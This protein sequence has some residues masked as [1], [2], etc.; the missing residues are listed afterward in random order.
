MTP[1][2]QRAASG[3]PDRTDPPGDRG[4]VSVSSATSSV[5]SG[6]LV[7]RELELDSIVTVLSRPPAIVVIEGEAGIGKT[8]LVQEVRRHPELAGRRFVMG[9]CR[10]IQEPFPL[11]P[12]L[13]LAR[14]L[15]GEVASARL[16]PV[17]GALRPLLPELAELLPPMPEPLED[18]VAARH[19]VF[20]GLLELLR[21]VS[22]VTMV[23]E[24]LH[25]ADEQTVGFL[26]YVMSDPP[27]SLS[28]VV[29]LRGE[30]VDIRVRRLLSQL[31]GGSGRVHV[32]LQPLDVSQTGQLAAAIMESDRVSDEFAAYLCARTGGL[33][34]AVE[35]VMAL[36]RER[37]MV[38]RG[39]EQWQRGALEEL[40]VPTAVRDHVLARASLL[41]K[42]AHSAMEA[43]SV[44]ERPATERLV[45]AVSADDT[46]R[47]ATGLSQAI[48][49]GL[50]VDDGEAVAFRHALASQAIYDQIPG[51]RR[52]A[53]HGRAAA[54][55]RHSATTDGRV[56]E[57]LGQVA[58][59]LRRA[60]RLSEW[61]EVAELAADRAI[62]LEH[63]DEAAR[64]LEDVL[65][66]A[67]IPS[68]DVGRL[69]VKLGRSA[70]ETFGVTSVADLL[71]E[72]L[73]GELPPSVRGELQLLLGVVLDQTGLDHDRVRELFQEVTE[74]PAARGDVRVW[75]ML[76]LA[77]RSESDVSYPE[78][79]RLVEK[80]LEVLP[81]AGDRDFQ[82]FT[83]G[84]AAGLY[85]EMGDPR[86]PEVMRRVEKITGD[87]PRRHPDVK[88]HF[89]LGEVCCLVG[90]HGEADRRLAA[91]LSGAVVREDQRLE[92]V[93]RA[94][95]VVLD[96]C[97]GRWDGLAEEASRLEERL[98]DLPRACQ[99]LDLVTG[100]LAL[101]RGDVAS[102]GQQLARV[103]AQ[104]AGYDDGSGVLQV[105]VGGL[106][107]LA[108]A[109]RDTEGALAT[110]DCYLAVQHEQML[111]PAVYRAL[112]YLVQALV[113][114]GRLDQAASL[115][116][117]CMRALDDRDAP[118]GSG[119][120]PHARG[121]L[122]AAVD[123]A[124]AAALFLTAAE[125]YE[126][127]WCP[128]EAALARESAAVTLAGAG[129]TPE[130]AAPLRAAMAT[131][132]RLAAGWDLDRAAGTARRY[133]MS[134]PA[135]HRGGQKGYGAVLSPREREVAE[136]VAT[137][138]TNQEIAA[139]LFLSTETVKKHLQSIR[140]KLGV[141]S[142]VALARHVSPS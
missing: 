102:A 39:G 78:R 20:R 91:A 74:N 84:K 88:A 113:A 12:V 26:H 51:P 70:I 126:S 118:L 48:E 125:Q 108:L 76:A 42:P 136:L 79:Q 103:R 94:A 141:S 97:C 95:R 132:Q 122:A 60:G 7:A 30:G 134:A 100:L 93:I 8:R 32:V 71:T 10:T 117:Q 73:E 123:P 35:E 59:H 21:E 82:V 110:V 72:V 135:R 128:Y 75:A 65:R 121:H 3:D 130:V 86:W 44:L 11:G 138:L 9:G 52:R 69:A 28:L 37:G 50:L 83:L 66:Y 56:P 54:A 53:L 124:G 96:Y 137:G 41:P 6:T 107:R 5:I 112:P 58:H 98:S 139:Q 105:A 129:R 16:S 90:H 29:T 92:V 111:W 47:V 68:R 81:T 116:A 101:A 114:A 13:E 49:A 77:I 119:A 34:F 46:E 133:G 87:E 80:V 45:A 43:L 142:R 106:V 61:A 15:R 127:L 120:L 4:D 17:V 131:Y 40:A 23:V 19:R 27:A 85:A 104:V 57:V 38:E 115:V 22:P 18:R 1:R 33:P 89:E 24:D 14:R 2:P 55:L 140:R 67:P 31:P 62:A 63:H 25:W 64:L 36:L 99:K 109:R